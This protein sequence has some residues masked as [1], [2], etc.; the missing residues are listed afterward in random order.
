[1]DWYYAVGREQQGPLNEAEFKLLVDDGTITPDTLVWNK[2][3][4]DWTPFGRVDSGKPEPVPE[5]EQTPEKTAAP[6]ESQAACTECGR[7]FSTEELV[8]F[9][10]N[11]V[12]ASCKPAFLQKI[13]E[14]VATTAVTYAGFWI[15]FGAKM[16]DYI[17]V[18]IVN[19]ALAIPISGLMMPEM[20]E[21]AM[22]DP[23]AAKS[24]MIASVLV[25]VV[26]FSIYIIYTTWFVG[27]FAATP[28]K[29]ACGLKVVTAEN[30]RVTYLRAF[31]RYFAEMV[32]GIILSIGYIMAAFD[33]EKR[34]LHDRFCST[35]VIRK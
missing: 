28:G 25:G 4:A 3:M 30:Q 24:M 9:N 35:R 15:R 1:M 29:M 11:L 5:I 31:A 33:D 7:S 21:S 23:E 19:Y 10:D 20:S 34:A 8:P 16:I 6:D 22:A 2:T 26:Q 18:S 17:I 32:S 12:C 14:G 27:K 13:R